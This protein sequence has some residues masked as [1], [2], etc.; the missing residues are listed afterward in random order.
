MILS[1]AK[2]LNFDPAPNAP[3]PTKP[4]LMAHTKELSAATRKLSKSQIARMMGISDKLAELNYE[5]FQAFD[6]DNKAKGLKQAALAFAGD[7]YL[8]LDANTLSTDD[9]RFAHDHLRILSGM[10]GL[11]RAL[12][13]IQPYRLEMGTKLKTARGSDLYAFWSDLIAKE[14]D[15]SVK[16]H[17]D[18]TVVIL[19]SNEY[20]KAIDRTALKAPSVMLNFKEVKDGKARAMMFYVKRARGMMARWAIQNRVD[21]VD[22]LKD[23]NVAGYRFDPKLSGDGDWIFSRPQPAKKA[24]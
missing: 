2:N 3:K 11:L 13:G 19:S 20:A 7:V 9:L 10:Y 1:P 17:T 6:G 12:D 14:L 15:K 23:F 18:K 22:G 16:A 5:R 21:A 8:G 4:T 24:A